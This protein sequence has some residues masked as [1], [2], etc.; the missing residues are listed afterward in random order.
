MIQ[1]GEG[2]GIL[3]PTGK[4]DPAWEVSFD[5]RHEEVETKSPDDQAVKRRIAIVRLI[6]CRDG[7]PIPAGDWDLLIGD[8]LLRLRHRTADPE[9]LVLSSNA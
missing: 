4:S 3:V 2:Y 1:D 6:C 9:W 7:Q 5:I 8:H